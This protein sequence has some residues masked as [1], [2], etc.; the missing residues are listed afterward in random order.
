MR[1]VIEYFRSWW[2]TW[3]VWANADAEQRAIMRELFNPDHYEE[4]DRP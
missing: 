1:R 4:A 3:R 2:I